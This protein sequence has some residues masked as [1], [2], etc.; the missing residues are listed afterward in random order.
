MTFRLE[1]AVEILR[2]TPRVLRELLQGLPDECL[3]HVEG[4]D[5]WSPRE[6]VGHLIHGEQD[7]WIPRAKIILEHGESLAFEPFDRF[8]FRERIG[9]KP[10]SALLGEFAALREGNLEALK[11]L[12]LS[13]EQLALKGT[14]P[15]FGPVTLA[16]LIAT[17]AVHDLSHIHQITRVMANRYEAAVGPWKEYLGILKR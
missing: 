8:G 5:T 11:A 2:R 9:D 15:A 12:D 1:E 3:T 4:P 17:W 10:C 16:Q 7:D 6:V 14:H 13:G